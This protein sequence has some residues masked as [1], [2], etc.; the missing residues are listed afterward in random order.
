MIDKMA[1]SGLGDFLRYYIN[2]GQS[3]EEGIAVLVGFLWR[4]HPSRKEM[5]ILFPKESVQAHIYLGKFG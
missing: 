4:V 3:V 5:Q 1:F 2:K